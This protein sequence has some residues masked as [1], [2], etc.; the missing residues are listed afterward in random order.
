MI[1]PRTRGRVYLQSFMDALLTFSSFWAYLFVFIL[2]QPGD[3]RVEVDDLGAALFYSLAGLAAVILQ[4]FKTIY[5]RPEWWTQSW[6]QCHRLS[7]NQVVWVGLTLC[8]AIV[9]IGDFSTSRLFL[10][11]WILLLYGVLLLANRFLPPKIVETVFDGRRERIA[12][13]G[14]VDSTETL[15]SWRKYQE[16]MGAEFFDYIPDYSIAGMA[17]L[18]RLMTDRHVTQ[19]ILLELPELKFH[20]QHVLTVSERVGAKVMLLDQHEQTFRHKVELRD[21]G[22]LQ[23]VSLKVEPLEKAHNQFLKRVVDFSGAGT[24]VVLF[25]P[26]MLLVAL[27]QKLTSSGT[28]LLHEPRVSLKGDVFRITKFRTMSED[29][30]VSSFSR[31]LCR[32]RIDDWPQIL[33]V[34]KGE[35]S[36]V[37]PRPHRPEQNE[38]FAVAMRNYHL[39]S[40][41]KPGITGLAQVRGFRG[42]PHSD[43]EVAGR[44]RADVEYVENWSLGLDMMILL[45]TAFGRISAGRPANQSHV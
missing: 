9:A 11:S 41:V 43:E 33:N 7:L 27:I 1:A 32:Y 6:K 16:Q 39:R 45:K 35:M 10:F 19:L 4:G 25:C 36:L 18:E 34:L 5:A 8:V 31:V 3:A 38:E 21:E 42:K 2:L 14:R 20:L 29:G 13:L 22:G 12:V 26:L 40:D 28:I 17:S 23:F 15:E 24:F 30:S 44:V 37:G